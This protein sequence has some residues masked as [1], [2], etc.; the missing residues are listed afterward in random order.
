[1]ATS[2]PLAFLN[3]NSQSWEVAAIFMDKMPMALKF[4]RSL[5]AEWRP[6]CLHLARCSRV[7]PGAQRAADSAR[8]DLTGTRHAHGGYTQRPDDPWAEEMQ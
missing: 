7:P 5:D 2:W 8:G 4:E 6:Y 1:M 3:S